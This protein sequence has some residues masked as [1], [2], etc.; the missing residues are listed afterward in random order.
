MAQYLVTWTIDIEATTPQAAAL[1]ALKIHR[2]HNSI[3][4]VFQVKDI[5]TKHTTVVDLDDGEDWRKA[6]A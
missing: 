3:A 5:A 2:D 6:T 1:Q 4:T